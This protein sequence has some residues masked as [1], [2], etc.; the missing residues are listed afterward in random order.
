MLP[1]KDP[2]ENQSQASLSGLEISIFS[3]RLFVL[4]SLYVY[5][6]VQISPFNK[7]TSHMD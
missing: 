5:L 3:L 4:S 2:G 6:C 7:N 1:L